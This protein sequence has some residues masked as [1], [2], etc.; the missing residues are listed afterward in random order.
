MI[1]VSN[2]KKNNYDWMSELSDSL[3]VLYIIKKIKESNF[4]DKLVKLDKNA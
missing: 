2:S 1:T 3:Y 4:K